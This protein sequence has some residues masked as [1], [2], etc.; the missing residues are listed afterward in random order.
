[1]D[2]PRKDD[3]VLRELRCFELARRLILHEVRTQTISQLTGLSRSRLAAL[4]HRLMVS[5][6]ARHRGPPP[7]SLDVFL[8]TSRGRTEGA[9]LAAIIPLFK[10]QTSSAPSSSLDDGEQACEI[11]DAYLAYYPRSTVRFEELMLLTGSLA[12]GDGI[13]LGLCRR[14]KGLIMNNRYDRGRHTCSH[15]DYLRELER[16][17]EFASEE[18][19]GVAS[20]H[21]L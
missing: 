2:A 10:S 3:S 16:V 15:C 20:R 1:M 21:S 11:Y 8:R 13:E 18:P 7:R 14:C 4:R 19:S 6:E 17:S 12:K 5:K 9:A